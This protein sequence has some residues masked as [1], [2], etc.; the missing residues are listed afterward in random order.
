M[1]PSSTATAFAAAPPERR[2]AG[3]EI[4]A[5]KAQTLAEVWP[6]I[7]FMFVEPMPDEAAWDRVMG[8]EAAPPLEAAASALRGLDE[9][10][11]DAIQTALERVLADHELKPRSLYQPIRVAITGTTISPGIFE[12]LAALGREASMARIDA[13][14]DRLRD[15]GRGR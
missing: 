6:L 3:C 2:R 10:R 9:W 11:Q 5:D 1:S 7:A 8:A 13:A 14:L 12:S 15:E 4:V